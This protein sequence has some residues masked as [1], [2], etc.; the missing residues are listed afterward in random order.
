MHSFAASGPDRP[1]RS[2]GNL[3]VSLDRGDWGADRGGARTGRRV[4]ARQLAGCGM[5]FSLYH[6]VVKPQDNLRRAAEVDG[7]G[8]ASF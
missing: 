6:V 4:G 8:A 2:C 7:F 1:S 3:E 5:M